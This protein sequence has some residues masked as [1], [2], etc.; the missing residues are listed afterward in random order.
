MLTIYK[1]TADIIFP[2]GAAPGAG[3]SSN[4]HV[5]ARNGNQKTILRGSVLAG[6]LRHAYAERLGMSSLEDPV[7]RWFGEGAD[8]DEDNSSCIR[9]ADAVIRCATVNERTHNLINRHTGAPA[10][11]GLFSFEAIPPMSKAILSIILEPGAGESEEYDAFIDHLVGILG[12]GLLVG[13]HTNRGVGRMMLVDDVSVR[14]F[15]LATVDGSAD[16]LDAQ[17]EEMNKGVVLSGR[18]FRP[19]TQ[20]NHLEIKLELGIPRGEDLLIGDGQETDYAL[21]PQSVIFNDGSEHWRIPG[22]S[23]R[24]VVRA[25]MTRLAARDGETITDSVNNWYDRCDDPKK[26]YKPDLIGWGFKDTQDRARYQEYPDLLDDPI[27]DLFGSMYKKGRIHISDVF[28]R[29][30]EQQDVQDRYHVAVDRFSGG[31]NEGALF[32]NQV[33]AGT[34]LIFPVTILLSTPREKEVQWLVKTLRALHL[35][36]LSVGSSKSGGRLE[37]KSISARGS[38][39]QTITAFARE[40]E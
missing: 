18:K 27:L 13:G 14:D 2:E 31:A 28:S 22:S 39:S 21:N 10:K 6:V 26:S 32:D 24:G 11:G 35:G 17:Y 34:Q 25:W 33:L 1:I 38:E 23:L 12:T 5:L 16:F 4:R 7:S 37:I 20:Q 29:P 19:E 8:P 9:V 36:I 3:S 40:I 15:D 30:M